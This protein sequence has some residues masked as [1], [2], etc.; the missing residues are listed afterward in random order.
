MGA[1]EDRELAFTIII[2]V[3]GTLLSN[4]FLVFQI[5]SRKLLKLFNNET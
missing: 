4:F 1:I 2:L 3:G 5:C